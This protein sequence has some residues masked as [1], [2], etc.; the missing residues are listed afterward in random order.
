MDSIQSKRQHSLLGLYQ[1]KTDSH[2]AQLRGL[3]LRGYA[4]RRPDFGHYPSRRHQRNSNRITNN[5]ILQLCVM[6]QSWELPS[7]GGPA[8]CQSR[9]LYSVIHAQILHAKICF[10]KVMLPAELINY[11][12]KSIL[13]SLAIKIFKIPFLSHRNLASFYTLIFMNFQL[14]KKHSP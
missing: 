3:C 14:L 2:L 13:H 9:C 5:F 11:I 4:T 7:A 10:H 6:L 12:Y 1:N 8:D